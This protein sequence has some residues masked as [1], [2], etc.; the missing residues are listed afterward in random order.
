MSGGYPPRVGCSGHLRG[1]LSSSLGRG[2][3]KVEEVRGGEI[4][5]NETRASAE[6]CDDARQRGIDLTSNHARDVLAAVFRSP[7]HRA[8]AQSVLP[9][10][11]GQFRCSALHVT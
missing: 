2:S 8:Y 9:D 4:A 5:R 3:L 6:D 7:G 10:E 1:H 11:P